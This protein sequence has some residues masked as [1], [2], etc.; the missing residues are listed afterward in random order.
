MAFKHLNCT[1]HWIVAASLILGASLA[2]AATGF[3]V[4]Q[5][6]ETLVT[7]GMSASQVREALG[8]PSQ[9]IKYRNQPGPTFTYRVLGTMDTLF[10]VDFD[11]SGRVASTNERIVPVDGGSDLDH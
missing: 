9:H 7:P 3:T 10:D 2:Q 1:V 8:R 5:S 6:Q 11:A 4:T